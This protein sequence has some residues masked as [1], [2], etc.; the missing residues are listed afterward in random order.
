MEPA[1]INHWGSQLLPHAFAT[2]KPKSTGA[3]WL[4][5]PW[6]YLLCE[7]DQAIP[8]FAQ[9][10][11]VGAAQ[12]TG[13]NMET[14]RVKASHSPFL[15]KPDAVVAYLR[16]MGLQMRGCNKSDPGSGESV[17]GSSDS[18]P[19]AI[20]PKTTHNAYLSSSWSNKNPNIQV[21]FIAVQYGHH[22]RLAN[23][24]RL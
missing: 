2:K 21:Q 19:T 11:M 13:S 20:H 23:P 3:A 6:S 16:R 8:I 18:A 12:E 10:A 17:R 22:S 14:E 24:S 7:L 1:E 9:E 15:S 5:I 4:A